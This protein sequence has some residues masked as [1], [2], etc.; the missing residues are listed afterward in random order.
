MKYPHEFEEID[1]VDGPNI[2]LDILTRFSITLRHF[3]TVDSTQSYLA[4]LLKYLLCQEV[5]LQDAVYIAS[6]NHQLF[7]R[8]K[9]N[10]S[11]FS[12]LD[13]NCLALSFMFSLPAS[14]VRQAPLITQLLALSAKEVLDELLSSQITSLKWPN[15]IMIDGRKIGG[16]LAELECVDAEMSAVVIGIGLNIDIA[17][18]V[19]RDNIQ[20]PGYWSPGAIF[21]CTGKRLDRVDV[22]N[23]VIERFL[24]KLSLFLTNDGMTESE[25]CNTSGN[26][27]RLGS[28]IRF[29]DGDNVIV[30]V[31]RG[32]DRTGG[33]R[34][35]VSPNNVIVFHSGE[36][37]R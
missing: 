22:R 1:L 21:Q 17:D 16:I 34:I 20:A 11:W 37:I 14:S 27:F 33:L 18:D 19:L 10:R 2:A 12:S 6:A 13:C 25:F 30:G 26:L 32:I 15:D 5:A 8:G 31:H 24:R 9:G 36:I 35:E 7:G 4:E 23:M 3:N 28:E 29:R